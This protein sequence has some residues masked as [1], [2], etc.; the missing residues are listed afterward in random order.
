MKPREILLGLKTGLSL[1]D[2]QV[3]EIISIGGQE[4]SVDRCSRWS[5][6]IPISITG[7][8]ITIG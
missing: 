4:L 8:A 6:S 3:A 5:S 7:W 2:A 1:D